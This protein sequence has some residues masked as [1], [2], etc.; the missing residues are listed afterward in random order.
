MT[1]QNLMFHHTHEEEQGITS[2]L[3]VLELINRANLDDKSE[4]S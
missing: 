3:E 4:P 2:V 1:S